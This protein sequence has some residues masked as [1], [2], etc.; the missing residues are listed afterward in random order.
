MSS[1]SS[2]SFDESAERYLVAAALQNW[3]DV[4]GLNVSPAWF[5]IPDARRVLQ[6][7][8]A[9]NG[10]GLIEIAK[11]LDWDH[12][13]V[14]AV[15]SEDPV[16]VDEQLRDCAERVREAWQQRARAEIGKKLCDGEITD[17]QAC[18]GLERIKASISTDAGPLFADFGTIFA[19]NLELERPSV[20][21][22]L[23]SL[24]LLYA[25]RINEL[26]GEPSV[27]K[28]NL[29]LA[30]SMIEM[31]NGG[32]VLY[33]DP[34]DNPVGI[35]RRMASF[36]ARKETVVERFKYAHNPSPDDFGVLIPWAR[37]HKPTLVVLDG[38]AEALAAEGLDENSSGD[39]LQFFRD[40][41]RPFADAGAAVLLSD[42]VTKGTEARGRW[43]RGSSAKL[44]RY[45]GACLEARLVASYSPTTAGS[46]RLIVSKDRCGGLG[47]IGSVVAE[48]HFEPGD[49]GT[50]IT[51]HKGTGS[52]EFVPTAIME[53]ISRRL[54]TMPDSTKRDLRTLGKSQ[55][56][57]IALSKLVEFG[58]VKVTNHGAGKPTHFELVKPFREASNE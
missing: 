3:E 33:L 45:D 9:L 52:T 55:F 24:A 44:G 6:A 2:Q 29:A 30:V 23:P 58:H 27:G 31:Q 20:A 54:E 18:A 53:K 25:G 37:K 22:I 38:V 10:G 56:V 5:S 26:H 11:H 4:E 41:V 19:G 7:A 42:H 46:V 8:R 12:H 47:P 36:G 49:D 48:I 1:K 57:E 13:R 51:F 39:V 28:T 35:A 21:R 17:D 16:I 50:E 14:L 32:T 15:A 34:E 40:R 43:A